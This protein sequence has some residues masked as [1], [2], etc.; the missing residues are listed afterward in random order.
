MVITSGVIKAHEIH[1]DLFACRSGNARQEYTVAMPDVLA[2]SFGS[3]LSIL[4]ALAP[5]ATSVKLPE[6]L[7]GSAGQIYPQCSPKM[8]AGAAPK[9]M[10]LYDCDGSLFKFPTSM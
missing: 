4:L 10:L 9:P 8:V 6:T 7:R 1:Y 2:L 3:I 5:L